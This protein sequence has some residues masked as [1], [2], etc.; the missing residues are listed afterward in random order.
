MS[1]TKGVIYTMKICTWLSTNL[2]C[3]IDLNMASTACYG[4]LCVFFH[5][6]IRCFITSLLIMDMHSKRV[7]FIMA[8]PPYHANT[9]GEDVNV[10]LGLKLSPFPLCCALRPRGESGC[11]AHSVT[12][13][14]LVQGRTLPLRFLPFLPVNQTGVK[15]RLI[16]PLSG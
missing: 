3:S 14:G 9:Y 5:I 1:S 15:R 4:V 6:I 16:S 10:T 12:F 11:L 2:H 7:M 8:E 13:T